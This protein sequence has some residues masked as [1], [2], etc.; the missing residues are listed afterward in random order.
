M[1]LKCPVCKICPIINSRTFESKYERRK[2]TAVEFYKTYWG[3]DF[4][5][6]YGAAFERLV[7]SD[8]HDGRFADEMIEVK[9]S[10]WEKVKTVFIRPANIADD[11]I[12]SLTQI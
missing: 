11:A 4:E 2:H 5:K 1:I 8:F 9:K 10:F 3:E 6:E 12:V 7:L